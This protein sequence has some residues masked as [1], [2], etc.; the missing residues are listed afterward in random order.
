MDILIIVLMGILIVS[1]LFL[2]IKQIKKNAPD[3]KVLLVINIIV[4]VIWIPLCVFKLTGDTRGVNIA[5]FVIAA[6]YMIF[7]IWYTN[8]LSKQMRNQ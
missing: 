6:I 5:W 7:T 1:Q 8:M 3:G 4:P 2:A